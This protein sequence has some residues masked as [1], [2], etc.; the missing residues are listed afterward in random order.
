VEDDRH[1]ALGRGSRRTRS[2]EQPLDAT[3]GRIRYQCGNAQSAG[4][5]TPPGSVRWQPATQRPEDRPGRRGS[6]CCRWA[7]VG[8]HNLGRRREALGSNRGPS[9]P[10][11]RVG[12]MHRLMPSQHSVYSIV[13]SV[14]AMWRRSGGCASRPMR[15]EAYA[16][17]VPKTLSSGGTTPSPVHKQKP[18]GSRRLS[19]ASAT[20]NSLRQQA[21]GPQQRKGESSPNPRSCARLTQVFCGL[22]ARKGLKASLSCA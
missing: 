5:L 10:R 6:S 18:R 22:Q 17:P 13:E 21:T 2:R 8:V 14:N 19:R 7:M 9:S 15:P 4:G 12:S 16:T 1:T 11:H 3:V 20:C